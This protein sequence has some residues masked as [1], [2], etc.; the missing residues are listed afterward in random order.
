MTTQQNAEFAARRK[1][2]TVTIDRQKCTIP[3][4]CKRCI[5]ICPTAVFYVVEDKSKQVR[6]KEMDPRE[7][8]N[9]ILHAPFVNKCTVCNKCLDV[10]PA[11]AITIS[12][13]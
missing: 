9:Y 6:L 5:Q 11:G 10:C 3:F 4:A 7:D 13:T 12:L 8:G 1:F 2:P